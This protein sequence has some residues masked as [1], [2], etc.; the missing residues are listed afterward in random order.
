MTGGRSRRFN[1]WLR[2]HQFSIHQFLLV[3]NGAFGGNGFT[4]AFHVTRFQG[5]H[6]SGVR[7]LEAAA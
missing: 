1:S 2:L 5:R 6:A 3:E 7:R 4:E